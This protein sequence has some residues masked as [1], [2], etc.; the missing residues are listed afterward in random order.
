MNICGVSYFLTF[1]EQLDELILLPSE[2]RNVAVGCSMMSLTPCWL[3]WRNTAL[4]AR[5]I[6]GIPE[7]GCSTLPPCFRVLACFLKLSIQKFI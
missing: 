4:L 3:Y 2:L 7:K 6:K 1:K 5:Y